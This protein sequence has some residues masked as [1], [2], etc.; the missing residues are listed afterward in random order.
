MWTDS[1]KFIIFQEN[2]IKFSDIFGADI[3]EKRN[4]MK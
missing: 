4:K 1:S 3:I 2:Q